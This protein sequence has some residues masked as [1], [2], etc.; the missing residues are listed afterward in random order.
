MPVGRQWR[1]RV[2]RATSTC[3]AACAAL[4]ALA[5]LAAQAQSVAH[6]PLEPDFRA[7]PEL[8]AQ[9]TARHYSTL[10]G[11]LAAQIIQIRTNIGLHFKKG[12]VLVEFDCAVQRAQDAHARA[13]LVQAEKTYAIDTRL[14][15]LKS[16]GVLELEVAEAEV[17]K[18]KA[19]VA[20]SEAAVSKCTI[21]APFDGVTVDQ[22]AQQFQY[23]TPGQPLLDIIDDSNLDVEL[24]VP[25][26]WLVWL[27]IGY[28]FDLHVEETDKI[29]QVKVM[30]LGGRVDPV[31]QSIK[32]YGEILSGAKELMAGM[33]GRAN[34][35]PNNSASESPSSPASHTP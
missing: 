29:Y 26:H 20:A 7:A 6:G 4:V 30:R 5:T 33:S 32:L 27:K 35:I 22:K 28:T 24:L 19:N 3:V 34:I 18:A 13:T 10:S 8:R 25:S 31:S 23:A 2:R 9:I 14:V 15:Q 17:A 16:M 11:E 1:Q 21:P 12:D